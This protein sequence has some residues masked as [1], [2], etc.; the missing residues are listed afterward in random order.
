MN[1]VIGKQG[2]WVSGRRQENVRY[3]KSSLLPRIVVWVGT[4]F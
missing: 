2:K 4:T 3:S 1:I